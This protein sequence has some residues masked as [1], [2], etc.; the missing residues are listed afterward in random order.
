MTMTMVMESWT[1]IVKKKMMTIAMMSMNLMKMIRLMML[2][3]NLSSILPMILALKTA[4]WQLPRA[5]PRH[6][7]QSQWCRD[8][9]S[10]GRSWAQLPLGFQLVTLSHSESLPSLWVTQPSLGLHS[11]AVD[12]GEVATPQVDST[13]QQRRLNH[14]LQALRGRTLEFLRGKFYDPSPVVVFFTS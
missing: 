10:T 9:R 2:T 13:G 4:G 7:R 5:P 8:L 3:M 14:R 11:P 1:M 12:H 6:E